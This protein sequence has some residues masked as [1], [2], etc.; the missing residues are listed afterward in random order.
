MPTFKREFL[1]KQREKQQEDISNKHTGGNKSIQ[2][3]TAKHGNNLISLS[4]L[5][6]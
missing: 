1:I 5:S 2:F 6:V 3:I 4:E